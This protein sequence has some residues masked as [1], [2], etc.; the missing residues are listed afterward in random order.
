MLGFSIQKL[1]FTA[2]AI[3]LVW[4]GF[5]WLGR[6]QAQKKALARKEAQRMAREGTSKSGTAKAAPEVEDMVECATCGS[7]VAATGTRNCGK[8]DCPYPG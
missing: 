5:K 2:A 7:F 1:L 4:Y 3:A 8:T 6:M